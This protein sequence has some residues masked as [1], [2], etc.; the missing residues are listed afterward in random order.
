M[1]V[2][3]SSLSAGE[4]IRAM[5]IEDSE[6]MARA[7]KVFP[8]VEDSAELPYIVYRRTQLEQDTT[9]GRRGADTVGIEILCYTKG[10]TEGVELAEAVRGALDGAQG[11]SDGLVMRSCYL[12]DSEEAWQDDAY[13]Q[14]L[15]F[16]VKI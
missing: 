4:I 11:E 7:N 9:K 8:V 14:Q 3:K 15:V 13:V 12:A 2:S 1:A 10:Y 6:V 5:L 16:N